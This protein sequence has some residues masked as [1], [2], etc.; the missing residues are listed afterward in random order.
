MSLL[1]NLTT[2]IS[3]RVQKRMRPLRKLLSTCCTGRGYRHP[4]WLYFYLT[5][6]SQMAHQSPVLFT[7][8]RWKCSQSAKSL[9]DAFLILHK[10]APPETQHQVILS[11]EHFAHFCM[12]YCFTNQSFQGT[13]S[14][15]VLGSSVTQWWLRVPGEVGWSRKQ[16]QVH[17]SAALNVT[18][19]SV[20]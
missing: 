9:C 14:G 12:D 19:F 4:L 17:L 2:L 20:I 16:I 3:Q 18:F 8:V 7:A 5:D 15:L 1:F 10:A 13:H 11:Q 6:L